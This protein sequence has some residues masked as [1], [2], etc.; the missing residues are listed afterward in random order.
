MVDLSKELFGFEKRIP[1]VDALHNNCKLEDTDFTLIF[2]VALI[3]EVLQT[4][5][6]LI[7]SLADCPQKQAQGIGKS[8]LHF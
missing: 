1:T 7:E 3:Q 8:F 5:F 4:D 2:E 6:T